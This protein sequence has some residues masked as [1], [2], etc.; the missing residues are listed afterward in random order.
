M[1]RDQRRAIRAQL[2]I[3][4]PSYELD[5]MIMKV[6][7]PMDPGSDVTPVT[8]SLDAVKTVTHR[9]VTDLEKTEIE[10][11]SADVYAYCELVTKRGRFR[12]EG[13]FETMARAAALVEA[14]PIA[15][16]VVKGVGAN[17]GGGFASLEIEGKIYTL[18]D[19]AKALGIE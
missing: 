7:D 18:E 11:N 1:N 5:R 16:I 8:R 14:I 6:L 3:G 15:P 12:G 10:I 13:R 2:A 9:Y 19:I 17:A 4:K